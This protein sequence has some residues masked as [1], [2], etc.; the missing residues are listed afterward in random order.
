MFGANRRVS[1]ETKI[2]WSGCT[3]NGM[4]IKMYK[5]RENWFCGYLVAGYMYLQTS[6]LNWKVKGM[7]LELGQDQ[8]WR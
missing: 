6:T 7:T 2:F 1:R 5:H 8:L 3:E 4:T